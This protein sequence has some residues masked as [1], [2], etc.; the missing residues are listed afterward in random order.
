[1]EKLKLENRLK[2]LEARGN[3]IVNCGVMRKILRK[4]R[5]LP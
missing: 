5:K 3:T 4:L 1:M 2:K